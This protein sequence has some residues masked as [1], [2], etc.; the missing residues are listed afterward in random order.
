[1]PPPVTLHVERDGFSAKVAV[2]GELDLGSVPE[3]RECLLG[4]IADGCN[5]LAVSLVGVEFCDSSALGVFVGCHRR[6]KSTEGRFE[7]RNPP[8]V[9]RHLFSVSGL[10]R[11]LTVTG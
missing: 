5:D 1:M 6:L 4:L 9:I 11:I 3:L 10:D 8:P 2:T 7:L